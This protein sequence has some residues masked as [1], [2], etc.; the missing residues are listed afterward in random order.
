[1]YVEKDYILRMI[2]E[3]IRALAKLLLGKDIDKNEDMS[4]PFEIE[5]QYKQLIGMVDRG[6]INSAEN[7]LYDHLDLTNMQYLQMAVM[8]YKYLNEA[9][10]SYLTEH[11]FSREEIMDGISRMAKCY[12][13]GS[14]VEALMEEND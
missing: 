7:I 12:G 9:T 11:D 14:I 13:F 3:M 4:L 6:E 1:M 2:H 10:D 5:E 8:F